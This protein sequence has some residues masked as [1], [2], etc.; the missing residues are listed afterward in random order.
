MSSEHQEEWSHMSCFRYW[1]SAVG[2]SCRLQEVFPQMRILS[3]A[4]IPSKFELKKWTMNA[5]K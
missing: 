2:I 4:Q 1:G 3:V 5:E